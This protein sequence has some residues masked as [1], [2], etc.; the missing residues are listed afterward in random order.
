MIDYEPMSFAEVIRLGQTFVTWR[1]TTY[2]DE[3]IL[4]R[5]YEIEPRAE[6]DNRQARI[7]GAMKDYRFTHDDGLTPPLAT[8]EDDE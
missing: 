2:M 8:D 1:H 3:Q 6:Y 7:M 5:R 4:E